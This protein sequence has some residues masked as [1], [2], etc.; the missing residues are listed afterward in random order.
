MIRLKLFLDNIFLRRFSM[1]QSVFLMGLA[2]A[3]LCTSGAYAQHSDVEFGYTGGAIEIEFGAEG[4]MFESDFPTSGASENFSAEPGFGS[5]PPEFGI[6]PND[7]IGYNVLENL[8]YW[9]GTTE[10]S[11][12]TPASITIEHG[13]PGVP[14]NIV[15]N[16]GRTSATMNLNVG[17]LTNVIGQANAS[18]VFHTHLDF[19][20]DAAAPNGAYGLVFELG[21]SAAG[22]ANSET[23]GIIF[24]HGLND[25]QFEAGA[26]H[27]ATTRGFAAVPEPSSLAMLACVGGASCLFRRRRKA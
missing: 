19:T 16:T 25:A 3:A 22:I 13:L 5:E 4:R 12:S 10:L 26:D 2:I 9:D 14:D 27:F 21:T 24:N 18:G 6:N 1:K 23:F 17:S 11:A 15:S 7:L 20:L 8:F